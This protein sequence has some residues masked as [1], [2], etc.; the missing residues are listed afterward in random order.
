MSVISKPESSLCE[1]ETRCGYW[2]EVSVALELYLLY[3]LLNIEQFIVIP[4]L[5]K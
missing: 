4:I 3:E 2:R 5:L 1:A